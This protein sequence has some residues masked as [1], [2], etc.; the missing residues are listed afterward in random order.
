MHKLSRHLSPQHTWTW[1]RAPEGFLPGGGH[2]GIF[3]NVFQRG[4]KSGEICFFPLETKK[5]NFFSEIFKTRGDKAP[6]PLLPTPMDMGMPSA[7]K[8]DAE[9]QLNQS[10][11]IPIMQFSPPHVAGQTK[12]SLSSKFSTNLRSMPK[13]PGHVS[14]ASRKHTARPELGFTVLGG[15][16][17]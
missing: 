6:L 17:L 2:Q 1:A 5:T 7:L 14:S 16:H 12:V 9:K 10:W 4:V 11:S 8:K 13:M 3:P 15:I